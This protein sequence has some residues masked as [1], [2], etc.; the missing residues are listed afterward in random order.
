[1][2]VFIIWPLKKALATDRIILVCYMLVLKKLFLKY[3]FVN[4]HQKKLL[5][6]IDM[7]IS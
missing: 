3:F 4:T 2:Q 1:M 5:R 7:E 6:V